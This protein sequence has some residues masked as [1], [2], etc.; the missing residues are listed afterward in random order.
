[1]S[2]LDDLSGGVGTGGPG[3]GGGGPGDPGGGGGLP[4]QAPL[5]TSDALVM[6]TENAAGPAYLAIATDPAAGD[7]PVWSISGGADAAQF[8]I[9]P[10]S[11]V[12]SFA[13]NPD[14]EAPADADHNN[15]YELQLVVTGAGG[16]DT[17]AITISVTDVNEAPAVTSGATASTVENT[18]GAVY[19]AAA[20][21]PDV[22]D[23]LTWSISGG[24]DAGL[25]KVD[26]ASGAVSFVAA[27]DFEAPADANHDNTYA[28][29]L[30]AT[31]SHGLA[32]TQAVAIAVTNA[33]L[34]IASAATASTPENGT[35]AVYTAAVADADDHVTWSIAGGADA[36]LLKIDAASGAVSFVA[37]PDFEAAADANHDN[38]YAVDLTATDSHGLAT[39]QSLAVSVTNVN[40][41][42]VFPDHSSVASVAPGVH[43]DSAWNMALPTDPD[44]GDQVTLAI[45]GQWASAISLHYYADGSVGFHNNGF[46][47]DNT[48]N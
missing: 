6:V 5:I 22:G 24:A 41:A 40:E 33:P 48:V 37:S 4:G 47:I 20:A 29:E 7:I 16:A 38:T 32:A 45:T 1:M 42:P 19:V 34:A 9:D 12:V 13:A 3:G 31:D 23:H 39:T 15:L 35:G 14:Y 30:T 21:D 43:D 44:A 11:G 36:S 25:M 2:I 8:V 17:K 28:I 10:S 26:A 18:A 27:P 46:T